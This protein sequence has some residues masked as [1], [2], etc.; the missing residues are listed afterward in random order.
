MSLRRTQQ[1]FKLYDSRGGGPF[2]SVKLE[3]TCDHKSEP[4]CIANVACQS[5]RECMFS[6]NSLLLFEVI[7]D[8]N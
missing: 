3:Q 6:L 7:Q 2:E 8:V 5:A 4:C 1:F